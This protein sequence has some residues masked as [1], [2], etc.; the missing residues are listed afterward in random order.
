MANKV[1]S[2]FSLS[3]LGPP[4]TRK[5]CPLMQTGQVGTAVHKE[6]FFVIRKNLAEVFPPPP[7]SGK[8]QEMDW[9]FYICSKVHSVSGEL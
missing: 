7:V 8:S 6:P 1:I 9:L 2:T 4:F 3:F 5:C